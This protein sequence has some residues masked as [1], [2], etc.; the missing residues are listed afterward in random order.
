MEKLPSEERDLLLSHMKAIEEFL[1]ERAAPL[2]PYQDRV[3]LLVAQID[4][5]IRFE[6]YVFR[7]HVSARSNAACQ[8]EAKA[9]GNLPWDDQVFLLTKWQDVKDR[10]QQQLETQAMATCLIKRFKV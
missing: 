6:L 3:K 9:L 5:Q 4:S 2:F 10:L 8:M 7:N 1:I